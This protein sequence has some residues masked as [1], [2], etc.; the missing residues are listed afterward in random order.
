MKRLLIFV[1]LLTV[2]LGVFVWQLPASIIA[3]F[4]PTE[5]GRFVQVHRITGTLWR[6]NALFSA[7]GVAPTLSVSWQCQPSIVPLGASCAFTESVA[8]TAQLNLS[9]GTLSAE[10]ITAVLPVHA[11]GTAFTAASPRVAVDISALTVSVVNSATLAV[12]GSVRA[13]S[14]RYTFGQTPTALGEVTIDCKPDPTAAST[15]CSIS[16]RGGDARLDGQ[17]NVTLQRASGMIELTASGAPAQRV[18]F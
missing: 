1:L 10:K 17:L 11:T 8:G 13:E 14:A 5:T 15:R 18:T 12:Q 7:M 16:N 4:L 2:A 9:A 6:G 3:G